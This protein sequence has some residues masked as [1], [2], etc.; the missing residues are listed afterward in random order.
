VLKQSHKTEDE[1]V[2]KVPHLAQ[3]QG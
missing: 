1:A 3:C 2:Q